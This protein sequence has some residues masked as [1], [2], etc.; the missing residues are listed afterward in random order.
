MDGRNVLKLREVRIAFVLGA[1]ATL[2]QGR[3]P[4]QQILGN[5]G[6]R[7]VCLQS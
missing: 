1:G 5:L 6:G 7:A 4:L 3:Y 2:A